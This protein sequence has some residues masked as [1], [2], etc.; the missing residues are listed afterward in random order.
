MEMNIQNFVD[1]DGG[2]TKTIYCNAIALANLTI[3]DADAS[4][5]LKEMAVQI[6]QQTEAFYIAY[7]DQ[8]KTE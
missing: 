3:A 4:E 1:Q 6:K 2:I 7:I 5:E 8:P